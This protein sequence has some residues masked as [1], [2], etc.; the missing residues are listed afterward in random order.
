MQEQ[1]KFEN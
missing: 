1:D